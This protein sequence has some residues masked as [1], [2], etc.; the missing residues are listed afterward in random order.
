MKVGIIGYVF[1]FMLGIALASFLYQSKVEDA[2]IAGRIEGFEGNALYAYLIQESL[3]KGTPLDVQRSLNE[4][5]I[6]VSLHSIIEFYKYMDNPR[7]AV[8]NRYQ[9]LYS[10][11]SPVKDVIKKHAGLV[12]ADFQGE[13]RKEA[14]AVFN[15]YT[16]YGN[17]FGISE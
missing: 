15:R 12:F 10:I 5:Y 14:E 2:Y 1:G 8:P 11:D 3:A 6:T 9:S 4:D 7:S 16:Q 17:V 13:E